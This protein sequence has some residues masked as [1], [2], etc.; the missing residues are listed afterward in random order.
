MPQNFTKKKFG[1]VMLQM[2]IREETGKENA[3][4]NYAAYTAQEFN[5][6]ER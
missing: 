3:E 1:K 4:E 6:S 2:D 5:C